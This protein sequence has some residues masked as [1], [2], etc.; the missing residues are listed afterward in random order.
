MIYRSKKLIRQS[1]EPRA[2]KTIAHGRQNQ[3]AGA[4]RERRAAPFGDEPRLHAAEFAQ[5]AAGQAVE[6]RD[7]TAKRFY[8]SELNR[9]IEQR[10]KYRAQSA[11]SDQ[12]TES[13]SG[14]AAQR[15][16]KQA[17]AKGE[18]DGDQNAAARLDPS[19]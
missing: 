15:E 3:R 7:A 8:H 16:S 13:D 14:I 2:K 9:R 10:F 17:R 12:K 5:T 11:H 6:A 19:Q 18:Q 1:L 4:D